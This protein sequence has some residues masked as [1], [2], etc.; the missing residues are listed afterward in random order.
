[1]V[2]RID[3]L[4]PLAKVFAKDETQQESALQLTL[5][6]AQTWLSLACPTLNDYEL[7]LFTSVLHEL[8][9]TREQVILSEVLEACQISFLKEI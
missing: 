7:S 2:Q 8:Y 9:K 3:A 6:K 5:A 4:N 1:M